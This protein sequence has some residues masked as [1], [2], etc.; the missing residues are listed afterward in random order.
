[1]RGTFDQAEL[2][3]RDSLQS[4]CRMLVAESGPFERE[5]VAL[6]ELSIRHVTRVE[7]VSPNRM[8]D[9]I[10][11]LTPCGPVVVSD[12]PE[13]YL[14]ARYLRRYSV[15]PVRFIVSVAAA[16]KILQEAFYQNLPGT[17]LEGL[18]RL[19][20]TNVKIYVAPMPRQAF[21]SATAGRLTIRELGD[22]HVVL[23]DLIPREPACHL[24]KY[25][26]AASRIV[27][28]EQVHTQHSS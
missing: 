23:D 19:L 7:E 12:Y 26:R 24:L 22:G 4:G 21:V 9:C 5:P 15:E 8:L 17:L 25:L 1:M 13:T 14:L 10:R 3:D 6:T 28:L 18:G 16:A 20:A 27:P 11:Q 2:L